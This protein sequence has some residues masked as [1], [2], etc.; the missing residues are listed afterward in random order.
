MEYGAWI[1]DSFM[2]AFYV[3]VA[4][5]KGLSPLLRSI[6]S[7]RGTNGRNAFVWRV[8]VMMSL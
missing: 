1:F 5:L 8:G 4:W 2:S 6:E 7:H 3:Y